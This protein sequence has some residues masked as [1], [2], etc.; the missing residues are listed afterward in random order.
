MSYTL[1]KCVQH[2]PSVHNTHQVCPTQAAVDKAAADFVAG[3]ADR[4]AE[5]AA[6]KLLIEEAVTTQGQI[7][8]FL[9]STPIQMLSPEGWIC[10]GLT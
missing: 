3:G 8:V 2:S 4:G 1:V 9:K 10:G 7:D 6:V 5:I